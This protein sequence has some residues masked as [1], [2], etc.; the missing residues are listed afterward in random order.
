M[1]D[2]DTCSASFQKI[3]TNTKMLQ[4]CSRQVT[5][6]DNAP[7]AGENNVPEVYQYNLRT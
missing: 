1:S 7:A 5:A 4:I 2:D 3:I 6:T